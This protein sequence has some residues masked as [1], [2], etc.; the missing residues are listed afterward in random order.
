MIDNTPKCDLC[1]SIGSRIFIPTTG[2]PTD[3]RTDPYILID[4][5]PT[6]A[7]M[8]L[9]DIITNPKFPS[10]I[11]FDIEIHMKNGMYP[12][13]KIGNWLDIRSR[14]IGIRRNS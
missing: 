12:P 3:R 6:H 13:G 4:L 5:C 8:V 7:M 11:G 14:S 9:V 2:D 10:S 1:G